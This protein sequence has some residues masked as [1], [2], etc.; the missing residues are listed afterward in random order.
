MAFVV[1]E[2]SAGDF[3]GVY[4]LAQQFSRTFKLK[5]EAFNRS[6]TSVLSDE[7]AWLGVAERETRLLG[8][9][10]G[11]DNPAFF[12]NGRVGW[13]EE[14]TVDSEFRRDGV[15]SELMGAFE[16]WARSR[17]VRLI[18]LVTRRAVGFYD[19]LGYEMSGQCYRKVLDPSGLEL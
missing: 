4:R 12:A 1:R 3:E 13:V 9:C 17:E 11:F 18:N 16:N 19:S 5:R 10:L 15:G 6:V 8:Y 14:I 2:A 7:C